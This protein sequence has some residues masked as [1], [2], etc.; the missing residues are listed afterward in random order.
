MEDTQY[1]VC[2]RQAV[3]ECREE[4]LLKASA[5]GAVMQFPF[6]DSEHIRARSRFD[7]FFQLHRQN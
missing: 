5:T 4:S 1:Y 7:M 3:Q 2:S 6:S